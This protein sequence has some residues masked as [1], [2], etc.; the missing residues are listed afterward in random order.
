[1]NCVVYRLRNDEKIWWD[2]VKK[3]Q[4]SNDDLGRILSRIQF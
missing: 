4:G 2:A 3:I 1:M